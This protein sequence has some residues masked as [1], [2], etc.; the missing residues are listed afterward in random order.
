MGGL[1]AD[2]FDDGIDWEYK[3]IF[4]AIPD[5]I[6]NSP[7][8]GA[9]NFRFRIK[10]YFYNDQK[11]PTAIQDDDDI[12]FVD[13]VK[14]LFPS[15]ITD[16]EVSNVRVLWP[17]TF[18]PAS[19]AIKIPIRVKL[20][21]NTSVNAPTFL[22]KVKIFKGDQDPQP[23]QRPIYCRIEQLPFMGP[24]SVVELAMPNWDARS[25]GQG[26]FRLYAN[27]IVPGRDLEPLND[28]TYSVFEL[29]FDSTFAYELNPKA[30]RNDVPDQAFTGINGRGLNMFGFSGRFR[31]QRWPVRNI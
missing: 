31:Q 20:S 15:E 6:I 28:T 18:A 12:Y 23:G 25:A 7:N 19:Q 9:K 8:E 3:K 16:I 2:L 30:P 24:G 29:A 22:V 14:L 13:N 10:S 5:T 1:R 11:S 17:Y 26:R 4:I 27:I 21:N